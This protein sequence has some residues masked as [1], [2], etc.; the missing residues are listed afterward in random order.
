[1]ITTLL[2]RT[3]TVEARHACARCGAAFRP[4][5]THGDCPVCGAVADPAHHRAADD[6]ENRPVALAVAAMAVN[7]L[8][9]GL[10]VWAVLG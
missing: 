6:G 2:R 8:V 9:F 10:V 3:A 5:L 1:M 7:L 4:S